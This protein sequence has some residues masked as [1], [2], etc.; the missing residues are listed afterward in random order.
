M[1]TSS[2]RAMPRRRR[3][4]AS[5]IATRRPRR[6]MSAATR[7]SPCAISRRSSA[8]GS[9]ASPILVGEEQPTAWLTDTS[10]AVKLFG[11][12]IVDTEQL[13]AW[14]A[15][16]VA[17]IDAEPRQADQIRGARWPVLSTSPSSSSAPDDAPGGLALS[18]EAHWNQNEADWRFFLSQGIV[19]G[20]RDRTSRLIATAA[21]LPYSVR[22]R[23][24]QHGA[25]DREL[26]P[27]RPR[28]TAG[29]CLPRSGG[30]AQA[31]RPGSTRRRRAPR[32][33][34]RLG[35][36]PTL[37]LRRLRLENSTPVGGRRTAVAG[38]QRSTTSRRAI[39]APWALIAAPC[40]RNLADVR[41]RGCCRAATPSAL[42]RDG[43]TARHIGPLFADTP[44][45]ALALVDDIVR[46]RDRPVADRR[47]QHAGRISRGPDRRAA[48]PSSGRFSACGSAAPRRP[49][50][51]CRSPS[52]ARNMDKDRRH[53]S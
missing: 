35:F 7:F 53:A 21:L 10:Q 50:R 31:S 20:M 22:Q 48:G 40:W 1:S 19:F 37:Q 32:F 39:G 49:Q 6:S 13:I 47:R 29:R 15:D 34:A 14:T 5:R 23:L 43:R 11:L 33:M 3:C 18:T 45:Q 42:V 41:T 12:P 2:G 30:Q 4:A 24:D 52:P 44:D 17:A 25:G 9:A 46:S 51:S 36:T 8:S 26:A 38:R 16:W 27:P 28:D